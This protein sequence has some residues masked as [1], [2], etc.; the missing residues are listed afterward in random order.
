MNSFATSRYASCSH[1]RLGF[2]RIFPAAADPRLSYR[3]VLHWSIRHRLGQIPGVD[4]HH[5]RTGPDLHAVHDRAGN[6]SEEDRP[7]RPG[8]P[9]C[10]CWAIGG[11]L[12]ARH[13]VLRSDR[14]LDGRRRCD[15]LYLCSRLCPE[16]YR[17]HREGFIRKT[18][19]RHPAWA[20]NAWHPGAAGYLRN[21]VFGGAAESR[22]SP[23]W[24]RPAVDRPR[25]HA[26][27]RWR[28]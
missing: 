24:R 1:G 7:R 12:P 11:R 10:L 20:H 8:D 17:H 27:C 5:L 2:W 22:Q 19:T 26:G 6:R 21:P 9:G 13:P 16:Q 25:R 3:R 23:A 28:W 15:A 4:Q 14:V 18:R